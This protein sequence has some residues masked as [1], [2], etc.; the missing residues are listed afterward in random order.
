M[1]LGISIKLLINVLGVEAN[2]I[3]LP[4]LKRI[5]LGLFIA[6]IFEEL[7]FRLNLVIN[8]KNLIGF[9]ITCLFLAIFFF[10]KG[11]NLKLIL[12]ISILLIFLI[13][14]IYFTQY[15]LII[16]SNYRFIFYSTA[17]LFGLLHIFNYSGITTSN[18]VWTPLLVI[19]QIIMGLLLG[20]LRV[21]YGFIY[22]V[23]CHSL[24]NIP[25]LFSFMK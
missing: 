14:L 22:A 15:K 7:L 6:P 23:I 4:Y 8:K 5:I 1:P 24:I 21:T 25:I 13:I 19:P 10:F 3:P 16:I 20:Y 18:I 12:F 2:Q 9:L 17:I 11:S